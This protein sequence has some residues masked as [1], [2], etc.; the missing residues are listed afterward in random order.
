M[1]AYVRHARRRAT[2]KA[3]IGDSSDPERVARALAGR[4]GA[5]RVPLARRQPAL[6]RLDDP[7]RLQG[8]VRAV[9]HRRLPVRLR[10]HHRRGRGLD[11]RAGDRALRRST[12]TCATSCAARTRGRCGRSPSGCSR[13]PT[14]GCGSSPEPATLEA[15]RERATWRPRASWRRRRRERRSFPLHRD[16]RPGG[17]GRGAAGLRG[18]PAHRRRARARRARHGQ[19]D[20]RARAGAAAAGRR[21]RRRLSLQRRP[22]ERRAQCPDGPHDGAER[23][24]PA[25]G[26]RRAAGRRHRRPRCSA[27]S[28]ST[29][30]CATASPPSSP[31]LLAAAHRGILYV[32]EVNLLPDHLVDVLL[33]AAAHGPRARRARRRSASAP[34]ALPAR[35]HDEPRGGRAAPA[36]A[37]PLRARASRSPAS[38]DPA[39]ARR[40]RAPAA[41]LRRRPGRRSPRASRA[42]RGG[43]R[44][45]A[46]PRA[47][48]RL[49]RVAPRPSAC[50]C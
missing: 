3:V 12:R 47:R 19:V 46:S 10:R 2:R 44:G 37:R 22:G 50:C 7:P 11:V 13:R 14:A 38:A 33:D 21:G 49:A 39:A 24:A 41:G 26:A 16:R 17:A 42:E 48:E 23:R 6:D 28:T 45:R 15:L 20:R 32:D 31:G 36:A 1:V 29:A 43:A 18:R 25:R 5:A 30:R 4:G 9:R 40:D 35:R 27:R 8:R 34:G